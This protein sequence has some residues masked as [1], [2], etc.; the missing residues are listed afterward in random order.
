MLV[1]AMTAWAPAMV[2]AQVVPGAPGVDWDRE[3]HEYT[4]EVLRAY[5]AL[6]AEWREAWHRGDARSTAELYSSH[7]ILLVADSLPLEGRVTIENYLRNVLP[8]TVEI[9][10]GLSDFVA[11]ERLAYA[12]GPF[13]FDVKSGDGAS[14]QVLTGTVVTVL[15]REGRRWRIRSQI[16]RSQEVENQ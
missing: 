2:Q 9:R 4:A 12:L 11:S 7:A 10:T 5:T 16:F 1:C 6:M 14:R 3:R 13:Y 8:R 15:V